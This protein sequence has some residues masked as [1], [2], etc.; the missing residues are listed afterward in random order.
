M[1]I[2]EAVATLFDDELVILPQ[3]RR[4]FVSLGQFSIIRLE[5][6]AQIVVPFLEYAIPTKECTDTGCSEE[7]PCEMF[8]QIPFPTRQF[9]ATGC[10]RDHDREHHD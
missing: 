7:D 1:Q 5:R 9:T 10:D 3:R 6:D 4:L 8:S 2:P